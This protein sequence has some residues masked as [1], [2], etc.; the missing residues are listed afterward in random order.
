MCCQFCHLSSAYAIIGIGENLAR[1]RLPR[2]LAAGAHHRG[3]CTGRRL[4]VAEVQHSR[5]RYSELS[6]DTVP[7]S[8]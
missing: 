6:K 1:Y 3:S 2:H 5:M 4:V 8:V 7:A